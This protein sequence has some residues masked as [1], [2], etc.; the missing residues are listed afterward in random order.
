MGK[1]FNAEKHSRNVRVI[2]LPMVMSQ[3]MGRRDRRL[4]E[5]TL[6]YRN[7]F[8]NKTTLMAWKQA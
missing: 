3:I 6:A 8:F 7:A 5:H 4:Q 2:P 1:A